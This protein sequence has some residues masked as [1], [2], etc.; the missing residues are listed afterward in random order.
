MCRQFNS[1]PRHHLKN[2]M[3]KIL[4]SALC[5]GIFSSCGGQSIPAECQNDYAKIV[6]SNPSGKYLSE[7]ELGEE[8]FHPWIQNYLNMQNCTQSLLINYSVKGVGLVEE[9]KNGAKVKIDF[10]V[11]VANPENSTWVNAN[12]TLGEDNWI[13]GK[14]LYM[15]YIKEGIDYK[16]DTIDPDL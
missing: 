16:I 14:T 6:Y 9:T 11:Q 4:I 1:V 10:D 8:L 2:L 3:K 15:T 13:T 5:L 7:S 12:G